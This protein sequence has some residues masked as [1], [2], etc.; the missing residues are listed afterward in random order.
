[1]PIPI[2][3]APVLNL[4]SKRIVEIPF[5]GTVGANAQ[6]T[7]VSNMITYPFRVTQAR[8]IFDRNARNLIRHYWLHS[9]EREESTTGLPSGD[10]IYSRETSLGY[11]IGQATVRIANSSIDVLEGKRF[12]K[13]HT[14]STLG[15]AY[16]I[17]ASITIQEI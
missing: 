4:E 3:K 9:G 14:V 12:I 11:F 17:S 6:I 15:V 8:M 16:N 2:Y 10:N 5:T 13:L 1:M 7:L